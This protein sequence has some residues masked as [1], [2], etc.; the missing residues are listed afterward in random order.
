MYKIVTA[1]IWIFVSLSYSITPAQQGMVEM[2]PIAYLRDSGNVQ[3]E[4]YYSIVQGA[5]PYEQNGDTWRIPINARV[6]IWLDNHVVAT[7]AAIKKEQIYKGTQAGFD[8]AK[9]S[10]MLDGIALVTTIKGSAQAALIL[11]L[12]NK[13]GV[14]VFDTIKRNFFAPVGQKDKFS[15]SGIELASTLTPTQDHSNP[16]EKVGYLITPNPSQL[17]TPSTSKLCY[18]TELY[19]P[20]SAISGSHECEINVRILDGEHHEVLSNKRKQPL[21]ASIIPLIG[22]LDV[23][24]LT[25]DSYRLEIEV[26]YNDITLS[27]TDE[28]F[29]Y[30]DGMKLTE[31]APT[32][33]G[34]VLDE[35][36]VYSSSD[37]SKMAEF[38]LQEKGDQA[39]YLGT[40]TDQKAWKKLK[41]KLDNDDSNP[42]EKVKDIEEER[43]FLFTFWRTKDKES[44]AHSPLAVFKEYYK[45]VDEINRKF[46]IM[47]TPGWESDF[48]RVALTYGMPEERFID[49]KN[50]HAI[51]TRP[52]I[53][54]EYYDKNIPLTST[55]KSS[56]ENTKLNYNHPVFVFLD[57]QGT[58]K[59]ELV[60]S[61]VQGEIYS[62]DW[63]TQL[64]LR[65]R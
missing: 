38:E 13:N 58:G 20:A 29:Y 46:T 26:K 7:S 35:E 23:D 47:K 59:F 60:H 57:V 1:F 50:L 30:D 63:Y 41:K 48:G 18:Y 33:S 17:Y 14:D 40:G 61:N 64:A 15:M 52:F 12:K 10:I 53:S 56:T 34:G 16:F 27:K 5:L 49:K 3:V 32:A 51:D 21:A 25:K 54:W 6:E 44:S 8:S 55:V 9:G 42:S 2:N 43:R 22:Y 39:M 31:D 65:T 45:H 37:L 4:V 11:R 24:G 19:V 36:T 28:K 62:P